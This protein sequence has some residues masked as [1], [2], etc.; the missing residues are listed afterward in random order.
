MMEQETGIHVDQFLQDQIDTVPHLEALLL[1]WNSRPKPWSVVDMADGLFVAPEAAKESW[2]TWSGN[3]SLAR[4]G[5][6]E[7]TVTNQIRIKI[8]SSLLSI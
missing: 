2:K 5:T 3:A 1:L 4:S 7:H 8:N 6:G